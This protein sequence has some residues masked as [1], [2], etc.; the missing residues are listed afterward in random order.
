M[1]AC[2]STTHPDEEYYMENNY[3]YSK[4]LTKWVIN[5]EVPFLYASSAATYGDG[6]Y[7]YND[8]DENTLRLKPLNMYG[9]SKHLSDA[10]RKKQ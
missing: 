2:S 4:T 8:S 6:S 7:G 3:E 9:Y 1:V 5:N 10:Q